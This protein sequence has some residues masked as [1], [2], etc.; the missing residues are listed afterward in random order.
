MTSDL[1]KNS[2]PSPWKRRK[3]TSSATFCATGVWGLTSFFMSLV[4]IWYFFRSALS[5]ILVNIIKYYKYVC[6]FYHKHIFVKWSPWT[7][8][9]R[10]TGYLYDHCLCLRIS[11]LADFLW[12]AFKIFGNTGLLYS[13]TENGLNETQKFM[14][15][16]INF[17]KN[18]YQESRYLRVF[19]LLWSK[20][21][22]NSSGYW[23]CLIRMW[24]IML[25]YIHFLCKGWNFW[26]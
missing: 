8:S 24:I 19:Q 12:N 15:P 2:T 1:K 16:I 17:S 10:S 22:N 9:V 21:G 3:P 18:P 20:A 14:V 25:I 7:A 6:I 11:Y 13:Y 26:E 5:Y 23:Y 4:Y